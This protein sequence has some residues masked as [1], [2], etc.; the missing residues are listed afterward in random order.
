M[1]KDQQTKLRSTIALLNSMVNGGEQHS[2]QSRKEVSEA[3]TI[4]NNINLANVDKCTLCESENVQV[5]TKGVWCYDCEC[6]VST[7]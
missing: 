3:L 1:T 6:F 4:I 2:E 7:N 5:E